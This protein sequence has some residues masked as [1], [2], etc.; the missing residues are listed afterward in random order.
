MY[1]VPITAVLILAVLVVCRRTEKR[2][3]VHHVSALQPKESIEWDKTL[4]LPI[5]V[6]G[7]RSRSLQ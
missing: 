6:R 5:Q 2:K 3:H 7:A 4:F 1:V